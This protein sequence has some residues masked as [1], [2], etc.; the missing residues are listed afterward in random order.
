MSRLVSQDEMDVI[1][2]VGESA[3]A[4]G[5]TVS[6]YDFR[7]PDRVAKEQLRSLHYL[8]DRFA[9]NV[10]TSL[11]AFLRSM[12][13]VSIVS[14]DQVTYSEF[15]SS[16]PDPTAFY[17]LSLQPLD[18][19]G[20]LELNPAVAFTMVDRM[21]GGTGDSP[22]PDRPLTEIEQ[23]VVDSVV[24]LMLDHLT[25]TWKAVSTVTFRMHAR[26]TRP[27][28]LQVSGPNEIVIR[29][30]FAVRVGETRGTL[31]LCIPASAIEAVGSSFERAWHRT[32][33]QPTAEETARL[34][35]NLGRVPLSVTAQLSTALPARE[36]LAM[37]PGDVVHLGHSAQ[38]PLTVQVGTQP[39][40][41][42]HL[43]L[44]N[45]RIA[46]SVQ[47]DATPPAEGATE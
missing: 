15:L 17:A 11:S 29:L 16:L 25:E 12:T 37:Q 47:G 27:Q 8:H 31:N 14:V 22:C 3:A 23:N 7:R 41:L 24:K 40:Y 44:Q 13:E 21:L 46:I 9:M 26:E 35:A 45:G 33:R 38:Q 4:A 39:A 32:R 36:L 10:T 5:G 19:L 34:T 30:G 43:T 20:A 2:A 28:M 18:M 42:G 6:V 1:L